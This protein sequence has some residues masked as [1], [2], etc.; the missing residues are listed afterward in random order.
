MQNNVTENKWNKYSLD[1]LE[2][3]VCCIE[4]AAKRMHKSGK[5]MYSI[6]NNKTDVLNDYVIDCY[7]V[8]H[9]QDDEYVAEDIEEILK[10]KRVI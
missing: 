8:L 9:T 2:F 10:G 4:S 6:L 7:E 5:E 3:A 1:E